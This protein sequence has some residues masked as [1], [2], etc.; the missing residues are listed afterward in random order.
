MVRA[1]EVLDADF[2][3]VEHVAIVN[4]PK[5]QIIRSFLLVTANSEQAAVVLDRLILQETWVF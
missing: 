2:K 5:H 3:H 4:A 1:F